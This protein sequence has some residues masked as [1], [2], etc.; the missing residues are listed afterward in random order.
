MTSFRCLL[1]SDSKVVSRIL[2]GWF[3]DKKFELA[4]RSIDP[5]IKAWLRGGILSGILGG[6]SGGAAGNSSAEDVSGVASFHSERRWQLHFNSV[7]DSNQ[8]VIKPSRNPSSY[9][10]G[11]FGLDRMLNFGDVVAARLKRF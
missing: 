1:D 9:F 6:S 10:L 5:F 3:V 4:G 11:F 2:I 7:K 8:L